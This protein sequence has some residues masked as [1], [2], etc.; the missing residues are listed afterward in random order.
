MK[1]II[2]Y[3]TENSTILRMAEVASPTPSPT[4]LLVDV[5]ATALNRADILQRKGAY[6][7]PPGESSILGLELAG[8]V[9]QVGDKVEGFSIREFEKLKE[10]GVDLKILAENLIQH[11]LKQ[12][13]RD[14]FFHGDMHQGNI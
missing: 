10:Y 2:Q 12:A 14:G 3:Q 6:P 11:F 5:K 9:R 1:A 13:V 7:P 8:V 4:Q